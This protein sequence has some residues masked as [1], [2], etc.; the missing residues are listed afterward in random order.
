M[1]ND[2]DY[3]IKASQIQERCVTV[4][5][6]QGGALKSFTVTNGKLCERL[7]ENRSAVIAKLRRSGLL[8]DDALPASPQP[9]RPE[10]KKQKNLKLSRNHGK[11]NIFQSLG[12][13]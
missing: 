6:L 10:P 3:F 9:K 1:A 8:V 7:F 12:T 5:P 4:G 13:G 11:L 2:L